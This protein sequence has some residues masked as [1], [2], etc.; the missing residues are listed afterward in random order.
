MQPLSSVVQNPYAATLFSLRT[1]TPDTS[2]LP[3]TPAP[4]LQ[5]QQCP[6]AVLLV[7]QALRNED[8]Y[9]KFASDDSRAHVT[10]G[11]GSILLRSAQNYVEWQQL[12]LVLGQST[13][14]LQ[15]YV[16]GENDRSGSSFTLAS[17][18]AVEMVMCR[19]ALSW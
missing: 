9:Q 7:S 5:H 17:A 12:L 14:R 15:T 1:S 3:R 6:L 16:P 2:T 11:G 10:V 13:T 4:A 18:A 8:D 19:G